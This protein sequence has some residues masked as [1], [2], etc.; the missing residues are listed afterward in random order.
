MYLDTARRGPRMAH[1]TA[2]ACGRR[3][4]TRFARAEATS[5]PHDETSVIDQ[6]S[7][8]QH[9]RI[10]SGSV[11]GSTPMVQELIVAKTPAGESLGVLPGMA[12][13]HG[14]ITGATGTG[15]TV[16]LQM[17]TERFSHIGVPVRS[18]ERRVG[19]ECGWGWWRGR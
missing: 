4:R 19:K 10:I 9:S 8:A 1:I 16:T 6:S 17:M 18:E 7:R 2:S 12:N 3:V 11:A 14:L 15:K 13:R 5:R